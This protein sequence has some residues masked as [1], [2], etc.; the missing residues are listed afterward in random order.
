MMDQTPQS[1]AQHTV[2]SFDDELRDLQLILARMGGLAE[3]QLSKALAA[4]SEGDSSLAYEAIQADAKVDEL[5]REAEQQVVRML[6]LRQPLANDLRTI[7]ASLKISNN[8]ERI[9]DYAKNVAKRA[10]SINE[11]AA[12]QPVYSIPR[13]GRAAAA[14]LKD[15]LDA[16]NAN[17]ADKALEVWNRDE[18]VDDLYT[19]FL[20]EALTYM[21]EDARNITACTHLLFIAKNLERI[22]DHCT[23]IAENVYYLV[24]G[25]L[26]GG[27]RPKGGEDELDAVAAAKPTP[28]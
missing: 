23:N 6:A 14:M 28:K 4:I 8:I 13:I 10:V 2:K 20:R 16:C 11:M 27:E 19:S 15:V 9:A 12:V 18:T 26:P 22:G 5:E 1:T 24:T 3:D 21:M 25:R 17:D 7:V